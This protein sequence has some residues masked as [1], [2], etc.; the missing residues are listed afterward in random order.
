MS[1]NNKEEIK[2]NYIYHSYKYTKNKF[3]TKLVL[4][5]RLYRDALSTKH[6]IV[7]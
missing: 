5:T 7:A 2:I 4:F 6:N 3:C 1:L